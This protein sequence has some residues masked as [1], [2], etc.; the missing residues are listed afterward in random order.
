MVR[1]LG[2]GNF[3]TVYMVADADQKA[4]YALKCV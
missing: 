4:F 3:G 2:S 1:K